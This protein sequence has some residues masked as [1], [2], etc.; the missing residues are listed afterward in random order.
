MPYSSTA[1]LPASVKDNLPKGA[2]RIFL[3][4][5]NSAMKQGKKEETAFKIAWGAVKRVYSKIG[6][7]WVKR[8]FEDL[9]KTMGVPDYA[10][11]PAMVAENLMG[12]RKKPKK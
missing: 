4:A 12:R 5:F 11:G 3:N 2:Q 9:G 6:E 1:D 7:E 8:S 10:M